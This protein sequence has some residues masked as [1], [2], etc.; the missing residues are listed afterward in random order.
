[1]NSKVAIIGYSFRLPGQ[2]DK[3]FWQNLVDG[4][5]LITQVDPE[6]WPFDAFHHPDRR[7]PGCSYTFSAG[8]IGDVSSFDA[9]FFGISPREAALMDPQQRILLELAQEAL[10]NSG[11][12]PSSIRGSSC[13]VYI[14]IASADYG[15][16]FMDDLAAIDSA[17]PTGNTSSI[18]ANRISYVFDLH[19]PSMAIDTACSAAMTSLHQAI[20]SIASGES[21][22]A[23]A[24]GISLH[25]HPYA[26][27]GFSKASMLSEKGRCR[28]F[29]AS[30]DGYVRSEGGG[31]F[32]LKDYYQA[33]ADGNPI[34][35]V[36]INSVL[37]ADGHK[38]G[39][40]VPNFKAQA[41]LMK[42]AYE[43]AGIDPISI[44]YIEA[45][46]TGTSVG[47]PIETRSIGE[48][49]G[50]YR[51]KENPLLIGSVKS[52]VGH[53]EPASGVAG[54]VKALLCIR[55]RMVPANIN[56]E[57]PNP[58]IRFDDWNI[59][60]VTENLP[61]DKKKKITIGVNSF[62]FGGANA[63][64]ILQNHD[65]QGTVSHPGG[66]M[67]PLILSAKSADALKDLAAD[68]AL[69]LQDQ[70]EENYYNIAYSAACHRDWYEHRAIVFGESVENIVNTLQ[71]FP[72]N[73]EA[74]N[75]SVASIAVPVSL[76]GPAFIYSGN[77]S[78]WF[79]M[80]RDLLEDD[81]FLESV[82]EVDAIFQRYADFSLELELAGKNGEG[83]YEF[84]EIAQPAL[85][86][87]QVGITSMLIKRGLRPTAAAGHSVGEIAA[88]WAAGAL[89]LPDA[90]QVIYYRSMLQ[91]K[92]KG[93]GQMTAVAACEADVSKL[94]KSLGLGSDVNISGVN[95]PRGV[96]V[97]GDSE[98]LSSFETVLAG[99]HIRYKRLDLDY[100]F[101][102]PAMDGIEENIKSA[103]GGIQP[104]MGNIPYYSTV[105]GRQLDGTELNADYWWHN[106]RKPVLF[107]NA[108]KEIIEKGDNLFI[109]VGPHTVLSGYINECLR[110]ADIEG[111]VLPTMRRN[112]GH[113]QNVLKTV[114]QAIIAGAEIDRE[115]FFPMTGNFVNIPN[116]PWQRERYWFENTS[117]SLGLLERWTVHPLLGYPLKQ[118]ALTWE[119]RLD[120][121]RLPLLAD[122][123][124]G[125]ETVFPGAGYA[126]LALAA[127]RAWRPEDA[128]VDIEE[129]E[130]TAPLLLNDQVSKETRFGI[131][132]KDGSFNIISRQY[133]SP[134]PW[135]Q[136]ARGRILSESRGLALL[137]EAPSV[138]T[139]RP[140]FYSGDHE[141]LTRA[142]GLDYG[143]AFQ[144]I[145]HGWVEGNTAAAILEVPEA[146]DSGIE[147]MH[148]H[149]AI[150][151]CTFQ[152]IIQLLK[153]DM[154]LYQGM[155]F[156]P[157]KIGR[158]VFRAE[159]DRP[160]LVRA[161]IL[162]RSPNSLTAEFEIFDAS[163]RTVAVIKEARFRAIR[164][165]MEHKDSLA[166][167][168]YHGIPKPHPYTA[169]AAPLSFDFI[170]AEI[171]ER[172]NH[173]FLQEDFHRYSEEVE[174]LLNSL[175]SQFVMETFLEFA[176]SEKCLTRETIQAFEINTP[177]IAPFL[178]CLIR[179]SE[180]ARILSPH[181]RNWKINL[182][183]E[184]QAAAQ[185][186]WNLLI[187]DYPDYFFL[188]N[189]TGR[190]GLNLKPILKGTQ[191]LPDLFSNNDAPAVP[192]S[193]IMGP[194]RRRKI[195]EI[196]R[197]LISK[198]LSCLQQ[199][200]RLAV[201]EISQETPLFAMD[202]C[203]AADFD[204][205]DYTIA[206]N[207][208]E[209]LEETDRF[210]EQ[211]SDIRSR[212]I[213][214]PSQQEDMIPANLFHFIIL[215]L[216][217]GEI[218]ESLSALN[219]AASRLAQGGTLLLIGQH[220]SSWIDFVFGANP[221]WFQESEEG[222]ESNQHSI[223]FWR[224]QMM[225]L[226]LRVGDPVELSP[227]S[228]SDVFII[229]ACCEEANINLKVQPSE[230]TRN[231]IILTDN[232]RGSS[233][234]IE[235]FSRLL[236][237][238][239]DNILCV[240]VNET[241]DYVALISNAAREYEDIAGIIHLAGLDLSTD[242]ND[243]GEMECVAGQT[244]RC[245]ITAD[246]ARACEETGTR[247]TLWIITTGAVD[248]LLPFNE[249]KPQQQLAAGAADSVLWGF[250]R[251]LLNEASNYNVRLIDIAKPGNKEKALI[252][253]LLKELEMADEEQEVILT[254]SGERF[255]PRL[256]FESTEEKPEPLLPA[257]E[258][259]VDGVVRLGFQFP[260]Q[261]RNLRWEAAP[262]RDMEEDDVE[263]QV[264]ATGLNF[265]DLMY[266]LGLLSDE[267]VEN[268]F[269]GASLG[270]E[271]AGIVM[272]SG[273]SVNEYSPG[274][275]VL[276]FGP[277]CFAN[278]VITKAAAITH[279]PTSVSF[280]S[281][282]TIPSVFFT[283]YYSLH[284]LAGLKEGEK[285]L[286]HGA[287]G[288]IGIAAVQL[289][290]IMGA[291]VYVT[292]GS[293]EKRDF[294]RLLGADYIY[295]SRSLAFAEEILAQTNG[296]GVDVVLNSLAGEAINRNL[297]VL[298]PFG[299]FLELGKL[300]FYENTKIGLRPFR[301]N[302]SYF[303][304][305][306]DQLML[307]RP[308]L[309][310]TLFSEVMALFSEGKLHPLPY[311]TFEAENIIDAFRYM[312]QARNIGKVV[313]TYYNGIKHV[314]QLPPKEQDKIVFPSD[315]T[316][317]VTGGLSGFGLKTAEWLA[318]KGV[319]HLVLISRSGSASSEAKEAIQRL[320]QQGVKVLAE[321][322]DVTDKRA[323]EALLRKSSD[324][325]P[326]LKGVVHAAAV[327]EDGLIVGMDKEQIRL[328]LAPKILGAQYLHQL[329]LDVDLEYFILFSS[330]TTLFGNPGQA[331]YVAANSWLEA[332]AHKRLSMG[333]PA[334]CVCWGAIDDVGFLARNEEIKEALQSR[335]GGAAMN[336]DLAL[337]KLENLL[338]NKKSGPGVM[339]LDWRSL[340]RFLP[341][342]KSPKFSEIASESKGKANEDDS[343]ENIH[344]LLNE[345][346]EDELN[347]IFIQILKKELGDI[348]RVSPDKIDPGRSIYDMGLDSL[349]GVELVVALEAR[350]GIR[351]TVMSL[352]DNTSLTRLAQVVIAQLKGRG[353]DTETPVD[354]ADNGIN[355]IQHL[356]GQ[357]GVDAAPEDVSE[358]ASRL[359]NR[360]DRE[361]IIQ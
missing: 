92:T 253:A 260:G 14:G 354:S 150:L 16:R 33:V 296:K 95:S 221:R 136:N 23:F 100:A 96:T 49:L 151:D 164:L 163:C 187:A 218:S 140:D 3:N 326:P 301:N 125:G 307:E 198:S 114:N 288:G 162:S 233:G 193:K 15:Y 118:Q 283:V 262:V 339:E 73:S 85:F 110:D 116:Y 119:N 54:L 128:V 181:D 9:G 25:L 318:S 286:I 245:A 237:E 220:P 275:R 155:V 37:N 51:P 324:A 137:V 191:N 255:V 135:T 146:I 70:K 252:E 334:T 176:D 105:T 145:S 209:A 126:E 138:L 266:T 278:R 20:L 271:F 346:P 132:A 293:D 68:Y 303:G 277:S 168:G 214:E 139:R 102:S 312:Q 47:D 161:A 4:R 323:L 251:T 189:M 341:S 98:S 349:M 120:S 331:N 106:I 17:A 24:G 247:T 201:M 188:I 234:F 99:N 216:D 28:V 308:E 203:L 282:A 340:S 306:A 90:V 71:G 124:V 342:A 43:R 224:R 333:L 48:G 129:L 257:S 141:I 215:T 211:F 69:F 263:I 274:D 182:E 223:K 88:A 238:K 204:R 184:N 29:D 50:K 222:W 113:V 104:V 213:E 194:D 111:R 32:V 358:L 228:L 34:H 112:E 295:N 305:D 225:E 205:C 42:Q 302:I 327:I 276:G 7:Q 212:L 6:R 27:I 22:M 8:S 76:H 319:R 344:F 361:T 250:A 109:E 133:M 5:D 122:H 62:G 156:V 45:H 166:F 186:I 348:L 265:R 259:T 317:L 197:E 153:E 61:L 38:S 173:I 246:L 160:Y 359:Q 65:M 180:E 130:I 330:A 207:S 172:V 64:V 123:V 84:T 175:C 291:Q 144:C 169:A 335:M 360:S 297:Q 39:I 196:I 121:R 338:I 97:A 272:R 148:L 179:L 254:E 159:A 142:V 147:Q 313:V 21:R 243:A 236:K 310:R 279:I 351:L 219:F 289:A 94:L 345:L 352:K 309:T 170:H 328:V 343:L 227:G 86:A 347:D 229:P 285:V 127:A 103:L 195:G 36:I 44:D 269:A 241:E 315:A 143:P 167:L 267:A 74:V 13:G 149:P 242:D 35:A 79:E 190:I 11:I 217:F 304:I 231:W 292:A 83:R 75:S 52:N 325:L 202:I 336:S 174:P 329:T 87:L 41:E 314:D 115:R 232:R 298:K 321:Q 91:G 171:A 183:E 206:T 134:E 261:L 10:E 337:E 281:A 264:C 356:V 55:H 299:R 192:V 89:S 244:E 256:R 78:Q 46:G 249:H 270:L 300:D 101:H 53:L 332:L 294:L 81:I 208:Q 56:L 311:H 353:G 284:H 226:G 77:G 273:S 30:A 26:F 93:N 18:A 350:F 280:E 316:F 158:I 355:E 59:K 322:C 131:E 80:G 57:T 178:S 40:T 240:S 290:K 58:I 12:K 248:H 67:P 357:H 268:G 107:E 177:D 210:R 320:E 82:R 19:G 200:G 157:T 117:E 152:L 185:D 165:E 230:K 258:A 239:G 66:L 31:I 154:H 1:M 199:G 72:E 235:E 63:H 60:V 287:A 2:D 108:I